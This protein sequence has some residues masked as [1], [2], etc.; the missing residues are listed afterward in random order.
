M[1]ER[2]VL[3]RGTPDGPVYLARP[4]HYGDAN[5]WT[6]QRDEA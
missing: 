1:A 6:G 3:L 2:F 5:T 4:D